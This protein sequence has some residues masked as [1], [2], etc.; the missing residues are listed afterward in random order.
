[1]TTK[2]INE[3]GKENFKTSIVWN[4]LDPEYVWTTNSNRKIV[5]WSEGHHPSTNISPKT[6]R[7]ILRIDDIDGASV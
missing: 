6:K 7:Y 2:D 3:K 1:M 5:I 4:P